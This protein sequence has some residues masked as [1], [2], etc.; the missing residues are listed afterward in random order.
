MTPTAARALAVGAALLVSL[1]PNV[2]LA[3]PNCFVTSEQAR[4][5]Y[6]GTTVFMSL[7]PLLLAG[8]FAYWLRRRVRT[9]AE[10]DVS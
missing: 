7:M 9:L 8:G 1:A 6:I 3:C 4:M 10:A 5:A 2:A